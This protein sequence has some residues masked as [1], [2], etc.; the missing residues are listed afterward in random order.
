MWSGIAVCLALLL[1]ADPADAQRRGGTGRASPVR[2]GY[3]LGYAGARSAN[4]WGWGV[5]GW[6]ASSMASWRRSYFFDPD[7]I[8]AVTFDPR[9]GEPGSRGARIQI[10]V[11]VADAVVLFGDH[12]TQQQGTDRIFE[13]PPLPGGRDV[14]YTITASWTENGRRVSTVR[15]VA[16]RPGAQVL[17]NFT[18][19]SR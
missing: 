6:G 16:V 15:R 3:A 12:R 8:G 7:Y 19:P 9:P 5:W 18:G 4:Y 14:H 17:V 10:L 2:P 13:T 11:P 1:T